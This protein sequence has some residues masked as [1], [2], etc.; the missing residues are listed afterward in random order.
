MDV[1][2]EIEKENVILHDR[3]RPN[4]IHDLEG[5][6]V[7]EWERPRI[8]LDEFDGEAILKWKNRAVMIYGP[9][10]VR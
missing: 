1:T 10:L 8:P 4:V 9:T 7:G 6:D 3:Q 2:K 5:S